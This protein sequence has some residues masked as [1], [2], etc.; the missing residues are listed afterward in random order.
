MDGYAV[1]FSQRLVSPS[2][3]NLRNQ[4]SSWSAA[5]CSLPQRNAPFA[6]VGRPDYNGGTHFM[7]LSNCTRHFPHTTCAWLKRLSRQTPLTG[8]AISS[9]RL[10]VPDFPCDISPKAQPWQ[11]ISQFKPPS[12]TCHLCF[13]SS[14]KNHTQ[15]A[16]IW[17]YHLVS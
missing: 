13:M 15:K 6:C 7:A 14:G 5:S 3:E 10:P 1:P 4:A 9:Q 12:L 16:S 2:M 11:T 8:G 17:I